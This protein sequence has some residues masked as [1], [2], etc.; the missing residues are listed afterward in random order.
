M[1][2]NLFLAWLPVILVYNWKQ[3]RRKYPVF[4]WIFFG[5]WFLFFPNAPYIITDLFHLYY[6]DPVPFWYDLVLL[7]NFVWAGLFLGYISLYEVHEWLNTIFSRIIGWFL[8][9]GLLLLSGFGMY[10]GRYL[11]WNSWDLIVNPFET[12]FDIVKTFVTHGRAWGASGVFSIFLIMSYMMFR[13]LVSCK[14]VNSNPKS[15]AS[16]SR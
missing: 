5:L 11:R 4:S 2:W 3:T 8:I 9:G 7:M 13:S 6:R 14:T 12:P 15:P 10:I 16:S 1:I